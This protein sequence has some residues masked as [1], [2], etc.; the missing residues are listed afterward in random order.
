MA[1]CWPVLA[2]L[3]LTV[4]AVQYGRLDPGEGF[5]DAHS[6]RLVR[7]QGAGHEGL[8]EDITLFTSDEVPDLPLS[9]DWTLGDFCARLGELDQWI[10]EPEWGDFMKRFRN[11]AFESAALDLALIQA[12]RP[13]HEVLGREPR[14][15]TYVNSLGLGEPASA[16]TILRRLEHYP[17]LRFKLDAAVD[18]NEE[19]V[20]TLVGTG[21][22]HTIDFK[23]H[24]GLDLPEL[25]ALVELYERLLTAFPDALVEDP[26]D[27][28]EIHALVAPRAGRVSY[29]APIHTVADIDALPIAARTLNIKPSRVGRMRDLFAVYAACEERGI[30]MYG[31]GMG[32]LGVARGQIQL[33]AA[34]FSPDGPNDIAPPGFNA[35]DPAPG[36]PP[37]P[38]DPDPAPVGFRRR[39]DA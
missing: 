31:G 17:G 29:D 33:L 13:L 7:L 4:E 2:A 10:E 12:G 30:A 24:Y 18:W 28:P 9:G 8:G 21:A 14:P 22:V 6:S 20:A 16:D 19:I 36:M 26:H 15:V 3:P 38:L 11:W 25:G 1:D 39:P 27:L 37:S 32:E 5:G 23:G 35:I 34:M